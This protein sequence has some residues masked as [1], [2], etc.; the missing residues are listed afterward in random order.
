MLDHEARN[1]LQGI[2]ASLNKALSYQGLA[3]VAAPAREIWQA[4]GIT[5]AKVAACIVLM[6]VV[7]GRVLPKVLW[8]LAG[9]VVLVGYGRAGRRISRALRERQAPCVA[10]STEVLMQAHVARAAMR[11]I[12]IP[13]TINGRRMVETVQKAA[14]GLQSTRIDIRWQPC[15][16]S[17]PFTLRTPRESAGVARSTVPAMRWPAATVPNA[18]RIPSRS[19]ARIGWSGRSTRSPHPQGLRRVGTAD[20]RPGAR[21]ARHGAI[22]NSA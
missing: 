12:A 15:P 22:L 4:I 10:A 14:R 16:G 6:L 1:Q 5:L 19:S 13:D 11:V 20:A 21:C 8:L 2:Y 7:G 18:H 9:Q 17:I 3:L